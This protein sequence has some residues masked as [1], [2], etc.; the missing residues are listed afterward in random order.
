VSAA[1]GV[2]RSTFHL[3]WFAATAGLGV[4]LTA[5]GSRRMVVASALIPGVL[6]ATVYVKNLMLFGEFAVSTFGPAS[7]TL[8]TVDRL[9]DEVRDAWISE[10]RLSAFAAMSVYSPPRDYARFFA[11]PNHDRWP[12]QLTRLDHRGVAAA[13]FNHWWLLEV[14]R[15][16][17]NDVLYYLR[18]RPLDYVAN[19]LEG[20][21]DMFRASTTW[22][23]RDG[24]PASPH[25]QHR[26][27]LGA[28]ERWFNRVVHTA[29]LAP[30]GLYVFLPA[31]L[32]WACAHAWPLVRSDDPATRARAALLVFCV[33]QTVYVVAASSML[34]LLESS[35]YRFQVEW[36][37][38]LL[39][40]VCLSTITAKVSAASRTRRAAVRLS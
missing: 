3:A 31:V 5:R 27:V 16:R 22:H 23:P 4:W 8:V 18:D 10:G 30:F 36:A 25:Y 29:P 38:W 1:I 12:P 17:R 40:A 2:T 37:I 26:Q 21:R 28:Y 14:H 13:N 24:T 20:V 35:R 39:T 6:L 33:C 9:P 15:T 32:L 7:Y 34:T 11:T 19:V